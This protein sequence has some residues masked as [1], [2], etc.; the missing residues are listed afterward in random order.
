VIAFFAS[1]EFRVG[2][3]VVSTALIDQPEVAAI[4]QRY[5]DLALAEAD[6]TE[7]RELAID[8]TSRAR[9]HDYVTIAADAERRAASAERGSDLRQVPCDRARLLCAGSDSTRGA[10][11]RS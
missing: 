9:G 10:K 6:F 8:E 7:V 2:T 11:A 3:V 1:F 4:A 5:V